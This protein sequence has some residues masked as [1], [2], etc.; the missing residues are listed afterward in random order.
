MKIL[1]AE[2]FF[3]HDKFAKHVIHIFFLVKQCEEEEMLRHSFKHGTEKRRK[4]KQNRR[5]G[6]EE[7]RE[8][9]EVKGNENKRWDG[10]KGNKAY[11]QN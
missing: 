2:R 5:N 9:K 8:K 1:T 6:E 3:S 4:W 7:R 10:E 11:M